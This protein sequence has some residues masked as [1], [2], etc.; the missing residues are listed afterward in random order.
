MKKPQYIDR[1]TNRKVIEPVCYE[2]TMSLLYNS[3]IGRWISRLLSRSPIFTRIYGWMQKQPWTRRKIVRFVNKHNIC[4]EELKKPLSEYSSFNDFF[5]RELRPTAR[6]IAPGKD[7]CIMP[8]DGFYLVYPNVAEFGEFVVKSKRFSLPKLL[9]DDALVKK[10]DAGSMVFSRL[11]LFNYHR[12]H[13]PADCIP[14]KARCINGYLFSVHP[15]AMKDN[16]IFFCENKRMITEL[17][18][19]LFGD[20]LYLEVGALSVGSIVQTF[21]PGKQYF[22]GDEKGFFEFGGSTIILLFQPN[23]IRFEADLLKNSRM[24]LETRCLMGQALGHA[25]RE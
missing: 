24:G 19:E 17:R 20:V 3:K 5:T 1:L 22:K 21:I 10:Y 8:S 14:G 4:T 2:K 13:F 12:F 11:A 15:I 9:R 23:K 6:S 25:L 16:F 7:V 18:T